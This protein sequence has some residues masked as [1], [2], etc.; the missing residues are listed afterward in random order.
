[1][2]QQPADSTFAQFH[3]KLALQQNSHHSQ[4]PQAERKVILPGIV[5]RDGLIQPAQQ[6]RIHLALAPTALPFAQGVIATVAISFQPFKNGSHG[7]LE[8]PR[9]GG[10]RISGTDRVH[11]CS[12]FLISSFQCGTNGLRFAVVFLSHAPI[13]PETLALCKYLCNRYI[14]MQQLIHEQTSHIDFSELRDTVY[15]TEPRWAAGGQMCSWTQRPREPDRKYGWSARRAA[16]LGA[17]VCMLLSFV[18]RHRRLNDARIRCSA[19]IG[20]RGKWE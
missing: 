14:L 18:S 1:M 20:E 15:H 13:M 4:G 12:A 11:G 2:P 7:S 10:N 9:H 8:D 16:G 19:L 17:A 3:P 5:L 6:F